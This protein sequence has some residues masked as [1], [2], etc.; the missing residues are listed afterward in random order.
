MIHLDNYRDREQGTLLT[1]MLIQSG[2]RFFYYALHRSIDVN[3][4][5]PH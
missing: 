5:P 1:H 3:R 4:A 2:R